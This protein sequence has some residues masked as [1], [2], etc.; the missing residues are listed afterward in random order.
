MVITMQLLLCNQCELIVQLGETTKEEKKL[1][2][3]GTFGEIYE[4][5]LLFFY[6]ICFTNAISVMFVF[7]FC[8]VNLVTPQLFHLLT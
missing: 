2:D 7:C 4:S 6:H 1:E 5:E 8:R 3:R